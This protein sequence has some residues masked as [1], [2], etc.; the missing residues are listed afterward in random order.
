[1]PVASS[2]RAGK[3]DRAAGKTR[4]DQHREKRIVKRKEEKN[5]RHRKVPADFWKMTLIVIQMNPLWR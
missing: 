2:A 1:M 4:S 3:R 5:G